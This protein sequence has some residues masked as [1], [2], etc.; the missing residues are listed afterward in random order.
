[1]L[2]SVLRLKNDLIQKLK[3]TDESLEEI[4]SRD[5]RK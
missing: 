3:D 1:M 2:E 4:L 5:K